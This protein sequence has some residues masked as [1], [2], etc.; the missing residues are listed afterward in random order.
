MGLNVE[1]RSVAVGVL[2][3][4]VIGGAVLFSY[5]GTMLLPEPHTVTVTER[6]T[7]VQISHT[8][9]TVTTRG[10]GG[11]GDKWLTCMDPML[12]SWKNARNYLGQTET[13][14]GRIVTTYRDPE[15]NMVFLNFYDPYEGSFAIVITSSALKNFN[16]EPEDFYLNKEV[17]VTGLI[18]LFQ[19]IPE[20]VVESPSQIEVAYM[21][22]NY[23]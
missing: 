14:E 21:G 6:L 8:T 16:F 12:I 20:I 17:R 13:V 4:A 15:W 1:A 11:C 10:D 7:S 5:S 3:G 23:P 19:E 9:K 2:L 22:F 18:G